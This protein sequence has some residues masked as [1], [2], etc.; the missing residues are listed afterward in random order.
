MAVKR[1]HAFEVKEGD[2]VL[3]YEVVYVLENLDSW[4]G[5]R[6]IVGL[7]LLEGTKSTLWFSSWDH[8]DVLD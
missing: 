8:V 6:A 2:V 1:K 7:D 3:D 4:D 5:G